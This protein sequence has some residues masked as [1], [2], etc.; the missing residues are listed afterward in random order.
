VNNRFAWRALLGTEPGG[1]DVPPAAVPARATHL[2]GLP[3]TFIV[4]GALDL[5]LEE[6][7]EYARRLIRSGVPTEIH[8]IPGAFHGFAVAG[9]DAPQVRACLGWRR[10][11]LARAFSRQQN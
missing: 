2:T 9:G 6:S 10:D 8:V 11:A 3:P 1:S 5:F 7:V 4:V